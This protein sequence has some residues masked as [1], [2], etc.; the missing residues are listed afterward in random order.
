[1]TQVIPMEKATR[2]VLWTSLGLYLGV[3][4]VAFFPCLILGK[5]YFANDLLNQYAH[6][7]CVVKDQLA[8]GHFPLWNPYLFGGQPFFAD[9]NVMMAYPLL[10]PTL[11]F[12]VPYG[13]SV[14]FFLHMVLAACGMHLWLKS[15]RLSD[16]AA[17]LGSLLFA[18]SGTFW[19]EIIHP[20]ILAAYAW[21]PWVLFCLE[22]LTQQWNARWAFATGLTFALVFC[23]GN[24]QS[25]TT[26]L[27]TGLPYFLFRLWKRD[28]AEPLSGLGKKVPAVLLAGLLG[29]APLLAHFIPAYEFSKYSNRRDASQNYDNFNSLFSMPPSSSYELLYPSLGVPQDQTIETAIQNITDTTYYSNDFLGAFGYIGIWAPFLFAL[30]FQRKDKRLLLFLAGLGA[31]SLFSA[32]GRFFPL[33]RLECLL[34]PGINLSR[35]PFRIIQGYV[36]VACVLSAFGFQT[37]ERWMEEKDPRSNWAWAAAGYALILLL[38]GLFHPDLA[39]REMLALLVGG[40]GIV[41]GLMTQSWK[42]LG[43]ILLGTGL[44]L[45][46]LLSGWGDFSLGPSS[47]YDLE[48]R[49]PAFTALK[50]E[51]DKGRIFFGQGLVYPVEM[52]GQNYGWTFPQD[53]PMALGIRQ[54]AGYNPIVLTK[55]MELGESP[56]LAYFRMMAVQGIFSYRPMAPSPDFTDQ[57]LGQFHF[58]AMK[59]PGARVWAPAQ[60]TSLPDEGQVLAAMKRSDFDPRKDA[61][62]SQPLPSDQAIVPGPHNGFSFSLLSEGTDAQSFKVRMDRAGLVV[63]SEILYPGWKAWVDG[64]PAALLNADHSFR[65]LVLNPGDHQVDFRF[66][67]LWAKPLAWG[68]VIWVLG[69]L[70]YGAF[71]LF[72]KREP[73]VEPAQA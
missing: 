41:L 47:N 33:H 7:R 43:R 73:K 18:L 53:G 44:V 66:E 39:W 14:F 45:P 58:Y 29:G 9:P 16:N 24:F 36:L 21:F 46:L 49:F 27:Y 3:A 30:A 62:L 32:W 56:L 35:A 17:R 60:A 19:W 37:L 69:A 72:G 8:L 10:Y 40:C 70:L 23:C 65:A 68:G 54:S 31:L 25:T 22:R 28:N 67:P 50:A 61:Y 11:L 52:G 20:P 64:Q 26:V 4:L 15:L 34:L 57:P 51:K 1:M 13:L 2:R 63:F 12:P 42:P 48:T 38:M 55:S 71:L 5:A 6:F 59:D